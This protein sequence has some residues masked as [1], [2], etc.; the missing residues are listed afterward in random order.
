MPEELWIAAAQT[1]DVVGLDGTTVVGRVEAGVTHRAIGSNEEW[2]MNRLA[3]GST[4]FVPRS[5][6]RI[7]TGPL[8]T[9]PARPSRPPAPPPTPPPTPRPGAATPPSSQPHPSPT[10]PPAQPPTPRPAAP[11]T[12]GG[13]NRRTWLI[14]AVAAVAIIAAVAS[15]YFFF[16]RDDTLTLAETPL[17]CNCQAAMVS[18]VGC[19]CAHAMSSL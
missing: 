15:G 9:P 17:V 19:R 4:G 6:A 11:P 16:L 13:G 14:A 1:A 10:A 5:R 8:P 18:M 7:V 12:G 3:D 2:F